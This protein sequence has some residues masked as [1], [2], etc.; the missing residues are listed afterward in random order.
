MKTCCPAKVLDLR[1][2]NPNPLKTIHTGRSALG[3]LIVSLLLSAALSTRANAQQYTIN[4]FAGNGT[5]GFS[6]NGGPAMSAMLSGPIGVGPDTSG[7]VYI[8]DVANQ[9]VRRVSQGTIST[10]AGD[11]IIGYAGDGSAAT[12]AMLNAPTRAVVDSS[13]NVY[14][15]D[16]GNSVVRMVAPNGVIST[17][18]GNVC[19]TTDTTNCG[20]GPYG[21]GGPATAAQLYTP[22]GLAIDSNGNLFI[23]DSNNNA[24]REVSGGIISTVFTAP[25]TLNHPVD[26]AVD[27]SDNLYIA[28]LD[29]N[30]I[31]KVTAAGKSTVFAGNGNITGGFSGD[32]G[33]AFEAEVD[34]PQGVAVDGAGNVYIADTLNNRI[35]KVAASSGII[36]TIAGSVYGYTGDGGPASQA[37]FALPR[38]VAVDAWGNVYVGDTG[39][40]VVR[41]LEPPAPALSTGGVVNAASFGSTPGISPGALATVFGTGF[42]VANAS[43]TTFP[44]PTNLAGVQVSVN[45]QFAPILYVNSTQVNFQVPWETQTGT[46]TVVVNRDGVASNT[47]TVPVLAAA[48]GLF[49]ESS[50]AAVVQNFVNGQYILNQ[51]SNAAAAGSTVVAYFT[52]TGPISG[53]VADGVATPSSPLFQVTSPNPSAMIGSAPAQVNFA[54]LTP[55]FA[56]L[57]QANIVIPSSLAPGTYP[58][59]ITIDG[60]T[61][62]SGMISVQ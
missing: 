25:L 6:G 10:F 46:A 22:L 37:T 2:Q 49:L 38:G 20:P 45:G 61:S 12:S 15:A 50:G 3:V 11:G 43:A 55:G 1:T 30:R 5:S 41:I 51:P 4:T 33:Q 16:A 13:G 53:T 32:G 19:T 26:V 36:T 24:I 54:G 7:N 18:V 39:N 62:N 28:D 57:A 29:N 34:Y 48:P 40:N 60:Q 47:L 42:L 58:L 9:V 23:A 52:G 59:T 21:D 56:G 17:I 27:S 35:R 31:V 44:L 8:A 14:I